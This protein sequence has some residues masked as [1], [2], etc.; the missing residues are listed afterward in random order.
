MAGLKLFGAFTK[1]ILESRVGIDRYS[2]FMSL[3]GSRTG[4]KSKDIITRTDKNA[5]NFS[6]DTKVYFDAPD[7]VV[8]SLEKLGIHITRGVV[9]SLKKTYTG[10]N[11]D[12]IGQCKYS[13]SNNEF[14][15]WLV[16][17]G[18]R[19]GENEVIPY[20]LYVVRKYLEEMMLKPDEIVPGM[21]IR[22]IEAENPMFE[23]M[24]LADAA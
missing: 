3:Y 18:Y 5:W 1:L 10:E 21:E 22:Q 11:Y 9:V 2:A 6:L 7:W 16:D 12:G 4:E 13:I 8:E 14:F 17:Y 24:L 20:D 19:L 23:A 15:W